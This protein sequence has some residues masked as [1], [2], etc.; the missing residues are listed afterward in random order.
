M[1][2]LCAVL[3][4]LLL[5]SLCGC[6][7]CSPYREKDFIGLSSQEIIR[8][9]GEFDHTSTAP[10]SEGIFRNCYC[11]YI[12]RDKVVGLFGTEPPVYFLIHFD[13]LGI[14]YKCSVEQGGWG[15]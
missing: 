5:F 11:G 6:G 12:I 15:G 14:A 4:I 9:F 2:K 13:A 8:Q 7:A 10:D 1:K 3:V